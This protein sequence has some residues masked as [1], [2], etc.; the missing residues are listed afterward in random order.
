MLSLASVFSGG[1]KAPAPGSTKPVCAGLAL[2]TRKPMHFEWWL[3]YHM[4]LGI[5]HFFIHV[6]DTPE[7]LPLLQSEPYRSRV[8]LTRKEDEG[9]FKDNYWTLQDRQRFHVNSSLARCRE[10]GIDW[11]FHVDDD[12]LIWLD[13]PFR[14][15][16]AAAPRGATNITFSN[17][18]AIPTTTEAVNFFEHIHTFTKRRMLAYVN[19]KPVG[20]T[21]PTVKLDGPHRFSARTAPCACACAGGR[22]RALTAAARARRT[23]APRPQAARRMRFQ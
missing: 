10:M 5:S 1:P 2:L 13:K 8:S 6:E 18:E 14:D 23:P 7:L 15:I 3:R 11:L 21:L 20:R 17:L 16:V 12:E 22:A 9:A 4:A 19:G